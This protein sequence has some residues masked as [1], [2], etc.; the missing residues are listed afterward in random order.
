M[1][2]IY[3]GCSLLC[4]SY[5]ELDSTRASNV[6]W[7]LPFSPL[8]ASNPTASLSAT[9]QRAVLPHSTNRNT[10]SFL[11]FLPRN[12]YPCLSLNDSQNLSCNELPVPKI[13]CLWREAKDVQSVWLRV[14]GLWFKEAAVSWSHCARFQWWWLRPAVVASHGGQL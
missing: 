8:T 5:T 2:S 10:S 9:L 7:L 6:C 1:D 11:P 3:D 13:P 4:T 12:P 14:G